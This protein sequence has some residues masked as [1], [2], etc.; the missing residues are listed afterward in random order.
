MERNKI[1]SLYDHFSRPNS[2]VN[3]QI[4]SAIGMITVQNSEN[5]EGRKKNPKK[6]KKKKTP[7]S[8]N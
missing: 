6:K 4:N 8:S 1:I 2:G 5:I 3:E 7:L